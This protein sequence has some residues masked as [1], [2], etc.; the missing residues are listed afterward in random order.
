MSDMPLPPP[1]CGLLVS[2]KSPTQD[3][4]R[5]YYAIKQAQNHQNAPNL[6]SKHAQM[7]IYAPTTIKSRANKHQ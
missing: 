2:I 7:I 5:T 6:A 4:A 3:L 1:F